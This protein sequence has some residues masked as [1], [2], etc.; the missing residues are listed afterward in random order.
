MSD[1][2]VQIPIT[3]P[4]L[5]GNGPQTKSGFSYAYGR[6]AA[7]TSVYRTFS[8]L[9]ITRGTSFYWAF[10]WGTRDIIG[11]TT[12]YNYIPGG[13][14]IHDCEIYGPYYNIIY[15]LHTYKEADLHP[16]VYGFYYRYESWSGSGFG[17]EN[18]STYP[19]IR[20][21]G[22]YTIPRQD[23][24]YHWEFESHWYGNYYN[25]SPYDIGEAGTRWSSLTA[26][27]YQTSSISQYYYNNFGDSPYQRNYI[28]SGSTTNNNQTA[29]T[30]WSYDMAKKDITK[31]SNYFDQFYHRIDNDTNAEEYRIALN[32]PAAIYSSKTTIS[33]KSARMSYTYASDYKE[34]KLIGVNEYAYYYRTSITDHLMGDSFYMIYKTPPAASCFETFLESDYF[35]ENNSSVEDDP[36]PIPENLYFDGVNAIEEV[37]AAKGSDS[38]VQKEERRRVNKFY[39]TYTLTYDSYNYRQTKTINDSV[40]Y[41]TTFKRVTKTARTTKYELIAPMYDKYSFIWEHS[42]DSPANYASVIY[43]EYDTDS[44]HPQGTKTYNAVA[45]N[46]MAKADMTTFLTTSTYLSTTNLSS[47]MGTAST[48]LRVL[49]TVTETGERTSFTYFAGRYHT[50]QDERFAEQLELQAILKTGFD[51]SSASTNGYSTHILTSSYSHHSF[52][53]INF[54]SY[55]K[56][57]SIDDYKDTYL[58]FS[59]I[60]EIDMLGTGWYNP[61][62]QKIYASTSVNGMEIPYIYGKPK[63]KLNNLYYYPLPLSTAISRYVGNYPIQAYLSAEASLYYDS[64]ANTI[65]YIHNETTLNSEG[66]LIYYN[67][68]AKKTGYSLRNYIFTRL[69]LNKSLSPWENVFTKYFHHKYLH[70][71]F[72]NKASIILNDDPCPCQLSIRHYNKDGDNISYYTTKNIDHKKGINYITITCKKN[73][74]VFVTFDNI[75]MANTYINAFDNNVRSTFY[76]TNKKRF[77]EVN[78]LNGGYSNSNWKYL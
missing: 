53:K 7:A 40:F 42:V 58:G 13:H 8:Y 65:K 38:P 75:F 48:L 15:S 67:Q 33:F 21:V 23:R 27:L 31:I 25:T 11:Y 59:V 6:G 35:I 62:D 5:H 18:T 70:Y 51:Y 69:Y 66:T 49:K 36:G 37:F 20:I 57:T 41:V 28:Y 71:F 54:H 52:Q 64:K 1:A 19:E 2:S 47:F 3:R 61:I 77:F 32:E 46:R 60:Q 43:F 34:S 29:H 17:I 10:V 73:E 44:S 30:L 4:F 72:S 76:R 12:C 55:Y 14:I 50:A 68:I 24:F 74:E 9:T 56:N 63:I 39:E 26:N 45:Y 16:K 22:Y 78:A